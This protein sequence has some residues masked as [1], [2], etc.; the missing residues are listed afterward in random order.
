MTF[1]RRLGLSVVAL[2]LAGIAGYEAHVAAGQREQLAALRETAGQLAAEFARLRGTHEITLRD[3]HAAEGQLA[4]LSSVAGKS[5]EP[6]S[7]RRTEMKGWLARVKEMR[8]LFD[9]Y[10]GQ[11]IPEM[12]F[13]TDQDWLRVA[14]HARFDSDDERRR[15]FAAVRNAA[16]RR[17]MP[18]LSTALRKFVQS[19]PAGAPTLAAL[20]PLFEPPVESSLLDRYAL[21]QTND[22]RNAP[23][24]RLQQKTAADPDHDDR[25]YV[26]VYADG[27]GYGSGSA[28]APGAWIENFGEQQAAAYKAYRAANKGAVPGGFAEVLPYFNPP[29]NPILAEKMIKAERARSR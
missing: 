4:T 22:R 28:S 3:L 10:P 8:R 1:H 25:H 7:A 15:A 29:L 16:I 9:E 27:R 14:K 18:R 11:Q 17:F 20:L 6:S 13:L 12:R 5:S 24:W 26:S 23:Q 2:G 21:D 19:S